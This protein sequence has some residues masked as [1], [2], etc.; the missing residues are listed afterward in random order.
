MTHTP[1][2]RDVLK[3]TGVAGLAVAGFNWLGSGAAAAAG[4]SGPPA[5]TPDPAGGPLD[6][7]VFGDT[8]SETA[9]AVEATLSSTVTSG[10]LGQSARVLHPSEPAAY[11]GG[12]L[13]VTL[14]CRPTG[15]TYVTVKLWGDEYDTTSQEQDS[16]ANSWRLQLFCEGLQIGHQD[17]GAVDNL[18]Q[19]DTAPRT[20]GRFFYHTLPLPEKL[21][22]GRTSVRLEIRAIGRIWPYGQ[23]QAQTF[24]AMTSDSRGI[25]R[26]YTHTDPYFLPAADDM[27]GPA[28]IP[29][30]R[31]TPG[32]D[33]LTAVRERVLKDQ[34][35][36]LDEATPATLDG[37]AMQS[38]AEGYLWSGSPAYR[39]EKALDRVLQAID[40]RY[41]AWQSNPTVLTASDQ[42]WQG[43]GRVGLVLALLWEQLGDRLDLPVTGS[44]YTLANPGFEDGAGTPVSWAVP[45]WGN[46]DGS[47][48][49]DTTV[50]RGGGASL[51]LSVGAPGGFITACSAPRIQVTAGVTYEYGTWVRTDGTSG[52]GA[53]LDPLFYDANGA[54]VGTDN[55]A[56]ATT[57]TNDW[58]YVSIRLQTPATATQ[59]ELHLRLSEVGT[60]WF[61]DAVLSPD[62]DP[63]APDVPVRRDAYV[64]M[65]RAS[66]DYWR[67]HFPHYSNQT[68]ICA[69]GIYQANRGL[70][71]L[72]AGQALPEA[73]ARDYLYQSIGLVSYSGPEDAAGLPSWPL[74]HGYYQVTRAGLTRELGYVGNYGEVTDW[75]VAMYESVTRGYD[76]RE[77]PEL[78]TQMLKMVKVRGFFHP[79]DVDEV[80]ARVARVES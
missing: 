42:Q 75:L 22:A 24:Y 38:L 26:L 43:F 60:A 55:K 69:T 5:G 16:G 1:S 66:R 7:V 12:T 54:L 79:V 57:G 72:D 17:Q 65:L 41:Y 44:P 70:R 59:V 62:D 21:T 39:Q 50:A 40:G 67:Q 25:Y 48:S 47:W 23:N 14:A 37:W 19:L 51:K 15:T 29:G 63:G 78:R 46:T 73:Q 2:R 58:H 49:R 10:G 71:L 77:A 28:P 27:Q 45:S 53:Y 35:Y 30:V 74:G 6:T 32:P 18:D 34:R 13:A 4:T 76:A 61:D 68:Q 31:T 64:T 8:A 56:Y 9:H 52:E 20:P 3:Y 11:W 36:L 33:A 80:G